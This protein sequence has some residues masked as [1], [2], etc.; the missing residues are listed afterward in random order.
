MLAGDHAVAAPLCHPP[1]YG[2]VIACFQPAPHPLP[3]HAAAP[4]TCL[5]QEGRTTILIRNSLADLF[6]TTWVADA[7]GAVRRENDVLFDALPLMIPRWCACAHSQLRQH[8]VQWA[9]RRGHRP[10]CKYGSCSRA[11]LIAAAHVQSAQ[12]VHRIMAALESGVP[13]GCTCRGAQI[14]MEQRR[15]IHSVQARACFCRLDGWSCSSGADACQQFISSA[16]LPLQAADN[17][18]APTHASTW[19]LTFPLQ[20]HARGLFSG[21]HPAR[22]H[23]WAGATRQHPHPGACARD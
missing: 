3:P 2:V 4:T 10:G 6:G 7:A 19:H 15:R 13:A 9:R 18:V 5:L 1:R 11:R 14:G 21:R 20:R 16:A 22:W 8:A 12:H 23:R 17:P